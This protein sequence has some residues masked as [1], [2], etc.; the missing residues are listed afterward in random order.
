MRK[1][2][3]ACS[4]ELKAFSLIEVLLALGICVFVI[5]GLIGLFATGLKASRDSEDQIEAADLATLLLATRTASPTGQ[6][7]NFAIPASAMTNAFASAFPTDSN[8]IGFDG[9]LTTLDRAAYRITC[10]AGTNSETGTGLSK[11]YLMLSWPPQADNTLP[12][13]KHYEV[14]T[15][16]PIR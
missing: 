12:A 16:V 14:L 10:R 5:V 11:L 13:T 15:Y 7:S 3:P 2:P 8:Y 9:T 4:P 1:S 6:I